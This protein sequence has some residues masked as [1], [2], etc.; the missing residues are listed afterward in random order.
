MDVLDLAHAWSFLVCSRQPR[1][2]CASGRTRRGRILA[3]RRPRFL[4]SEPLRGRPQRE[5]R[6][7][8]ELARRVDGGEEQVA[9]L[10]ERGIALGASQGCGG[11]A[12]G[13]E[14][15]GA[16]RSWAPADAARRWTLRA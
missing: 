8:L 4:G 15:L 11:G 7:D 10:R 14:G 6:V 1:R 5:L 12:Y 2:C 16:S 9:Q 3:R 13:F